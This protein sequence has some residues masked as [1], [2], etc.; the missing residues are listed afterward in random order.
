MTSLIR[1]AFLLLLCALGWLV[2]FGLIAVGAYILKVGGGQALLL[3][4]L[5]T[6]GLFV[7]VLGTAR[8]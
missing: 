8:R 3:A 1:A 2:V 7:L 4:I 5:C 6:A